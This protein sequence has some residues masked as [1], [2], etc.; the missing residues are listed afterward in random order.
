MKKFFTIN[1]TKHLLTRTQNPLI[2]TPNFLTFPRKNSTS[3]PNSTLNFTQ[4][5]EKPITQLIKSIKRPTQVKQCVH[6][7]IIKE[8]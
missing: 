6:K 3:L 8:H 7:V 1:F 4:T 5:L 2:K